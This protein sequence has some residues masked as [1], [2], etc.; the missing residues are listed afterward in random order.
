MTYFHSK[1]YNVCFAIILI[2]VF[3]VVW[4]LVIHKFER[5]ISKKS[6]FVSS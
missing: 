4:D 5:D 6:M 2:T 1:L 3:A